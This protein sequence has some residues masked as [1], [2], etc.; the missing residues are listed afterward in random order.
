MA[1]LTCGREP[2]SDGGCHSLSKKSKSTATEFWMPVSASA[3]PG[4]PMARTSR[5]SLCSTSVNPSAMRAKGPAFVTR[6]VKPTVN[7]AA[8]GK[9]SNHIALP[10]RSGEGGVSTSSSPDSLK[11]VLPATIM[12]HCPGMLVGFTEGV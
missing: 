6:N 1:R 10:A 4:T 9:R 11:Y 2:A 5:E 7:R 12:R 3:A 8:T